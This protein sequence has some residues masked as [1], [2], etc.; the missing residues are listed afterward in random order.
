M[1]RFLGLLPPAALFPL[2]AAFASAQTAL[3]AGQPAQQA[4]VRNL[5]TETVFSPIEKL[6]FFTLEH[7]SPAQIEPTDAELLKNRNRDLENEA[8][9]YGYDMS[10]PGWSYE[11]SVCS[12]MPDY[13]MLGY[14]SKDTA[15]ADSI[16]TALVPRSGGR[17]L[18]VPV[19]SHGATRFKPA[20]IDP[21]NFQI[22]SQVVPADV[23]KTNS[24]PDGKWLLLSVCYAEMTGARPQVPNHPSMDVR[25]IKAPPPTLRISVSGQD[26][27]VRFVDPISPT[28]YRL[29]DISYDAKGHVIGVSDDR[30]LFGQP[31]VKT[32]PEPTPKVVPQPGAS[33]V[34]PAEP[35]SNP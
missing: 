13:V 3:P 30:Q 31:I 2:L 9:F 23:A 14:T 5:E 11:Q 10:A 25:M 28:E 29:W 34:K 32:I 16:F 15:G 22:F 27:E 18:V 4:E 12:F 35:K 7:R 17:V 26:H 6:Q 19:L 21:R 24:G 1:A 33:P 8:E 20:A